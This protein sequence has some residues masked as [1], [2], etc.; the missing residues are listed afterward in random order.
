MNKIFFGIKEQ[1]PKPED[2]KPEDKK[3]EDKKDEAKADENDDDEV[4]DVDIWHWN[5]DRIQSVQMASAKRDRDFTCM[6]VL[7]I[8]SKKFHQLTDKKMRSISGNKNRC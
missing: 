8:T 6:G 7:L 5:D 4:A 1:E 2:K 3:D